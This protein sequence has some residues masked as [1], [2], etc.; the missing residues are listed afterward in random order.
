MDVPRENDLDKGA[1]WG[2]I[3]KPEL[4]FW[5]SKGSR[6]DKI[7]LKRS[8]TRDYGERAVRGWDA[9]VEKEREVRDGGNVWMT[10]G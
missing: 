3:P 8:S 1:V 7:L 9:L 2:R 4:A 6:K 5:L 10:V